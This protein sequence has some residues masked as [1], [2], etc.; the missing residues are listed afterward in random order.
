MRS[1]LR[2][3]TRAVCALLLAVAVSGAILV[4][5]TAQ[6]ASPGQ[7]QQQ[8]SAGQSHISGLAGALGAASNRLAK[9]NAGIASLQARM[10][11]IQADLDAKR[12]QL[13]KLRS[14][15]DSARTRLTQ[16]QAFE[17]RGEQVLSQQLVSA[18]E[19]DRPDII[20]VVL[21]ARGFKDLLER[22][23]FAQRVRN[24]SVRIVDRVRAARRA[25][26]AQAVRLGA[27]DARQQAITTQVLLQ[28]N[29]LARDRIS[30]VQQQISAAQNRDAKAS[31]L[32]SARGHVSALQQQLSKLQAAQAAQAAQVAQA[33]AAAAAAGASGSS[34]SGGASVGAGQVSSG[35]GF[36]FPLPRGS[37][38][39]PGGWT[40][41][42]GVDIAA[43]GGT[44]LLA[45]C[46]G[47]VV[48]HGIGGFGPDA[49]VLHC[50]SPLAGYSYVYYGHAGPANAVA[51]GTHVGAGQVISEVGP[52][53]VGFST[54]PHLEIGFSDG[55]GT[56]VGGGSAS[57]MMSLLRSSYGG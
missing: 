3:Y 20:S 33:A 54:G 53:I 57:A 17:A 35:G 14:E 8:I 7:L 40:L 47:T 30:L 6:A 23:S 45:V 39:P 10:T 21:E 26:A 52:G 25:V 9:L 18:Y 41:D 29:A 44:S 43:P 46:S 12:A 56:P 49:P 22:L 31:A 55:S 27:L 13:L 36:T 42:Q 38:V 5:A 11:R 16:L 28:R 4:V 50:D 51:I 32:A 37:A 24:Q 15:L 2:P 48:L 34:G 19:N 1:L